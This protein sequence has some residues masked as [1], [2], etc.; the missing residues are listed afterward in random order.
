MKSYLLLIISFLVIYSCKNEKKYN[1]TTKAIGGNEQG[2]IKASEK[3]IRVFA[4]PDSI[5]MELSKTA[6]IVVD[7]ENDFGSKGG[8]F[9]RAGIDI[10]MIK[11]TIN[12]TAKVL[13][14][15]RNAGIKIIYLKMGYKQDLSDLGSDDSPNRI[16]HLKILNVGDT[17]TTPTGTK[18]RILIRN[19]WGTE[20]VP[21]LKP[22]AEDIVIY[23]TR[24][25]GF[26]K[27]DLDS[28]LTNLGKKYL[29]ITGCT[30]SICVESTV[31]DAMYR[32]YSSIVLEDCTAEP[33]GYGLA[34]SNHMASILNIQVLLGWVS[35]S[36]E[37]IKSLT[38]PITKVTKKP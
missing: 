33:I 16:R 3:Q 15:A 34:R 36:E 17:I 26:F 7:M 2:K 22:Q 12:P 28:I 35:S 1:N 13:Q 10:S 30:T 32:D 18:S 37:F 29:I 38:P 5:T 24:F 23:K 6:V 27:T 9:D 14:V 31:R 25:S 19:L 11:K 21:E 4:K 20:I 8:M